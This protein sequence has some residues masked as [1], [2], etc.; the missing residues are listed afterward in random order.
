MGNPVVVAVSLGVLTTSLFLGVWGHG[1]IVLDDSAYVTE[2]QMVL[3]GLTWPGVRWAFMTFHVSN[4]HPLTWLSHMTDVSL[5]GLDHLV[6]LFFHLLNTVLL[7]FVLSRMT[8]SVWRSGFAAALFGVHPLHVESVAWV[9]ERKDLLSGLFF[10]LSLW[11]YARYAERPGAVRYLWVALCFVLG[12]LSGPSEQADGGDASVRSAAAGLLAAGPVPGASF[13][14]GSLSRSAPRRDRFLARPGEGSPV[15]AVCGLLRGDLPG[16]AGGGIDRSVPSR[17]PYFECGCVLCGL[18]PERESWPWWTVAGSALFLLCATWGAVWQLRR[19]PYLA[20]GWF[21]YLGMLVP[22][23]GLV[24]VGSQAMADRYTYLPLVGVFIM[25]V[26]GAGEAAPDSLRWKT[27]LGAVAACVFAGLTVFA[28]TQAG[29]WR[30][31]GSL[32]RHA[33]EVDPRNSVAHNNLGESLAAEGRWEESISHYRTAIEIRPGYAMAHYN[34]GTALAKQ[35]KLD[36]AI[37]HYLAALRYAPDFAFAYD[38]LGEALMRQGKTADAIACFQRSLIINVNNPVAHLNLGIS[39]LSSGRT[40]K[41]FFHYTAALQLDPGIPE[42]LYGIGWI[43]EQ[44]GRI[45]EAIGYYQEAIR[46][47]PGYGAVQTRLKTLSDG[48]YRG[49]HRGTQRVFPAEQ[50]E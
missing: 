46:I 49:F 37:R 45:G 47:R 27:V 19:R 13:V 41:A 30:N 44:K 12:L 15:V 11:G 6:S 7:F 22:V 5:F 28:N 29:H 20:V 17:E 25:I 26:W 36:D 9:A 18:H 38:N 40:A 43:L 39:L 2:N 48:G 21:W 8:G 24:Q 4:W 32:F 23:I 16:A 50:D 42:A 14:R 31:N 34:L 1:F 3:S 33:L 10:F 35:G